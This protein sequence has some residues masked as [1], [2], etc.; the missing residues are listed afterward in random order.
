MFVLLSMHF[1][2]WCQIWSWNFIIWTFF[3]K[4]PMPCEHHIFNLSSALACRMESIREWYF[5]LR[6]E[7]YSVWLELTQSHKGCGRRCPVIL[8]SVL[9][10]PKL[11]GSNWSMGK[12]NPVRVSVNVH[13]ATAHTFYTRVRCALCTLAITNAHSQINCFAG[14]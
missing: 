12:S 3:T 5:V 13:R 8:C 9:N 14:W 6:E 4:L 2:W 7:S 1:S 10:W 11:W